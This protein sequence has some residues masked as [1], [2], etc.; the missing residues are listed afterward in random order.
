KPMC[1]VDLQ[2]IM[3]LFEEADKSSKEVEVCLVLQALRWRFTKLPN[4]YARREVIVSYSMADICGVTKENWK[5][6]EKLLFK[7]TIR[8]RECF[9]RLLNYITS[10]YMGITYL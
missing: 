10:D 4:P 8:V 1:P 6:Q 7:S 3:R 5:I 9:L 2:K